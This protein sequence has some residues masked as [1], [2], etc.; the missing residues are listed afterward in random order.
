MGEEEFI[1]AIEDCHG[2]LIHLSVGA[3]QAD[4]NM[5]PDFGRR[6][7]WPGE[8]VGGRQRGCVDAITKFA[9]EREEQ[10][11]GRVVRGG[12]DRPN[13]RHGRRLALR[14]ISQACGTAGRL[15][16]H[17]HHSCVRGAAAS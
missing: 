14:R 15:R 16:R 3:Q 1:L 4:V 8:Q 17:V 11:E 5:V 6:F 12:V 7:T 9:G 2:L 10:R 13:W